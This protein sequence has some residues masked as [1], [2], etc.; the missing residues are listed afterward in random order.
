MLRTASLP[1]PV[2]PPRKA[3]PSPRAVHPR[4]T[5][6][7][8]RPMLPLFLL[9]TACSATPAP[10]PASPA[11]AAA[12]PGAERSLAA[13]LAAIEEL[14]RRDEAAAR[15]MDVP[16]LARLWTD[17]IVALPP[18]RPPVVG[19]DENISFAYGQTAGMRGVEILEYDLDFEE[20]RVVGDHAFEW[21]RLHA[22]VQPPGGAEPVTRELNV[23]RV[24]RRGE[25]GTWRV[26]RTLW[27]SRTADDEP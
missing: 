21:G 14:H 24:L 10:S 13:D 26:A 8:R 22:R 23:M 11:S 19:R 9:L 15:A 3:A 27:N 4:D 18:G 16:A 2:T 17:D 5:A 7:W 12:T 6:R 20:V 25:D 1:R